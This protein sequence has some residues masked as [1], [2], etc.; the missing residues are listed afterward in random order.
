MVYEGDIITYI[1][2]ISLT[3]ISLVIFGPVK[4]TSESNYNKILVYPKDQMVMGPYIKLINSTFQLYKLAEDDRDI[5]RNTLPIGHVDNLYQSPLVP[6]CSGVF[7]SP[8]EFKTAS[9]CLRSKNSAVENI[10]ILRRFFFEVEN[11]VLLRRGFI[12]FKILRGSLKRVGDFLSGQT[13]RR[14]PPPYIYQINNDSSLTEN[15]MAIGYPNKKSGEIVITIDCQSPIRSSNGFIESKTC[16]VFGGMSGGPV[17][18]AESR[19]LYG[20]VS[21]TLRDGE[22]L[23]I[24]TSL[25]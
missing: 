14:I 8:H 11:G 6:L 7:T 18:S 19:I 9:H 22:T 12:D 21:S 4:A 1:Q 20:V 5:T 10:H 15:L 23:S 25:E 24:A 16:P 17:I 3:F 2:Y 13:T